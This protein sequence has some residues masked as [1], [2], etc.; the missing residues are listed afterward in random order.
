MPPAFP[1]GALAWIAI[2]YHLAS[3]LAYVVGVGAALT[4]QKRRAWFT[5]RA[6]IEA[7][8]LRFR[9]LAATLMNNDAI[10]FALLCLVT[11]D[12]LRVPVSRVVLL[13]AGVVCIVIGLGI[14]AWARTALG[15]AGYH[16][17]D[18]FEPN[19]TAPASPSGPYRYL[20]NPMYTVGYLHAYGFAIATG[21]LPGL[22]FAAFDQL[23]ILAFYRVVEKPHFE[24]LPS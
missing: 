14:K 7:G 4:L 9:R 11:R 10:S 18:F 22:L 2:G 23:A 24:R 8:Y 3:R 17:R 5:R 19:P 20:K 1:A 15:S 6:G 16:W 21:S 13:L 12:T